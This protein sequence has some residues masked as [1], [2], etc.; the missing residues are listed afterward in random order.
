ML[1]LL[2]CGNDVYMKIC[3]GW[4]RGGGVENASFVLWEWSTRADT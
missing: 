2:C 3:M 4:Y 1:D